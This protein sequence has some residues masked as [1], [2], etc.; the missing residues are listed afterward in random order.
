MGGG[1]EAG[2]VREILIAIADRTSRSQGLKRLRALCDAAETPEELEALGQKR[3]GTLP[4]IVVAL[5]QALEG[6]DE[7]ALSDIVAIL[8]CG[9]GR[10]AKWRKPRG[11]PTLT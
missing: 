6:E 7:A 1:D 8:V 2:G 10:L 11:H 3:L 4:C 5:D 9:Y